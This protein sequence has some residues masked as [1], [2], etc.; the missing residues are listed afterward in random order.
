MTVAVYI[1][2]YVILT[3]ILM[4]PMC[5]AVGHYMIYCTSVGMSEGEHVSSDQIPR[6]NLYLSTFE[7]LGIA[8]SCLF[9]WLV[10]P[11]A[12]ILLVALWAVFT[13]WLWLTNRAKKLEAKN[14]ETVKQMTDEFFPKGKN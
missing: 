10:V 2:V 13:A 1:V 11:F 12:A 8:E 4:K 9:G 14:Q 7:H 5:L 6:L 3:A